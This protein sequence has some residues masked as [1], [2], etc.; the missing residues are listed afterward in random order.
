[1]ISLQYFS[2]FNTTALVDIAVEQ[3]NIY[4]YQT[5]HNISI[6]TNCCR[7]QNDWNEHQNGNITTAIL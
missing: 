7:R 4:S 5:I 1:M 3:T 6:D 2:K